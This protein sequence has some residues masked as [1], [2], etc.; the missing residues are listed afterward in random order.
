MKSFGSFAQPLVVVALVLLPASLSAQIINIDFLSER[1]NGET[2]A[3]N[4]VGV[5][6]AGGGTTFNGLTALDSVGSSSPADNLT[7]SGTDFVTSYD[8]PTTVGF[9]ITDV[10]ADHPSSG[11]SVLQPGNGAY[12]FIDSA[13]NHQTSVTFTISGLGSATEEDLFFYKGN[14]SNPGL[15]TGTFT[16]GG[17]T[18]VTYVNN[19]SNNIY[20]AADTIE[21]EDVPVN[22]ADGGSITGT[23]SGNQAVVFSG[24]TIESVP[25]PSA[26]ALMGLGVGVLI[27]HLRRQNAAI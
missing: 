20:T 12:L 13:E 4:Y 10:G 19:T 24:L 18:K 11:A 7:V 21:F 16:V 1:G 25:E 26:W 17:G 27:W 8:L 3:S 2:L 9:S 6:A 5:G 22:P 14:S 23:F 15:A